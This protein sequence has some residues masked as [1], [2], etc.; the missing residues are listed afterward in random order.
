MKGCKKVVERT[1]AQA[2][3]ET[4]GTAGGNSSRREGWRDRSPKTPSEQAMMKINVSFGT[5]L[6]P[7]QEAFLTPL[8][9]RSSLPVSLL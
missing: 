2:E 4:E 3:L 7:R 6:E 9:L 5:T 8:G 1:E